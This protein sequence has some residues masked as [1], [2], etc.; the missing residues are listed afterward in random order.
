MGNENR[1][2][3][4]ITPAT[5]VLYITLTQHLVSLEYVS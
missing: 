1:I 2:P 5:T 4:G 3:C